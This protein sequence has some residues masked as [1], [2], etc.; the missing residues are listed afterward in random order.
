MPIYPL[1][2]IP[3]SQKFLYD[4]AGGDPAESP[5]GKKPVFYMRRT[6]ESNRQHST[7]ISNRKAYAVTCFQSTAAHLQ[8]T[9]P[10][11]EPIEKTSPSGVSGRVPTA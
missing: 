1:Q 5:K 2:S 7:L 8:F 4:F 6:S 11:K 9:Q 10:V 3:L